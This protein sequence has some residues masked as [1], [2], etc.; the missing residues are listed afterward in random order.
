LAKVDGKLVELAMFLKG[1]EQGGRAARAIRQSASEFEDWLSSNRFPDWLEEAGATDKSWR[2]GAK[3]FTVDDVYNDDTCVERALKSKLDRRLVGLINLGRLVD[4][5]I[6]PVRNMRLSDFDMM[7]REKPVAEG[8]ET[9]PVWL[10]EVK[11]RCRR[12]MEGD[13]VLVRAFETLE[14]STGPVI[15][16]DAARMLDELIVERLRSLPLGTDKEAAR[17]RHSPGYLGL[18]VDST[19]RMVRRDGFAEEVNLSGSNVSWY[20]FDAAYQAGGAD[21]ANRCKENYPG[22]KSAIR[23]AVHALNGHLEPLR[24][25]VRKYRLVAIDNPATRKA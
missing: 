17:S 25:H 8:T 18:I 23:K 2:E 9:E 5:G 14:N 11:Y 6:R 24:V 15:P 22:E 3:R 7:R 21:A 1:V 16:S 12:L 19:N 10:A 13:A 4:E 20:L